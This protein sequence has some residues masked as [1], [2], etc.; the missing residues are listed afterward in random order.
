MR[1]T[2]GCGRG[3]P[4]FDL[5]VGRIRRSSGRSR[6]GHRDADN[7][8][9]GFRCYALTSVPRAASRQR[10]LLIMRGRGWRATYQVGLLPA[11]GVPV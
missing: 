11:P 1:S 9:I 2:R 4:A 5:Q 6:S 10:D 8:P 3:R 7:P